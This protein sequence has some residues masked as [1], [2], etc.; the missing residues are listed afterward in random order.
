VK[1][2]YVEYKHAGLGYESFHC[3]G[4]KVFGFV[5]VAKAF[6][7]GAQYRV[8]LGLEHLNYLVRVTKSRWSSALNLAFQR[9]VMIRLPSQSHKD[10]RTGVWVGRRYASINYSTSTQYLLFCRYI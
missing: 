5:A 6:Y 3:F 2:D 8:D 10:I 9:T 4:A 1:E 7:N